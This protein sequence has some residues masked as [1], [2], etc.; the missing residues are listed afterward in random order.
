MAATGDILKGKQR[1]FRTDVSPLHII[2]AVGWNEKLAC[3][4]GNPDEWEKIV[5]LNLVREDIHMR[6]QS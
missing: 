2:M 6:H 3:Y 1:V 4:A 5:M